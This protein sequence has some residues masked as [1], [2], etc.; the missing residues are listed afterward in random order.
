VKLPSIARPIIALAWPVPVEGSRLATLRVWHLRR[1]DQDAQDAWSVTR[2]LGDGM[3]PERVE[4]AEARRVIATHLVQLDDTLIEAPVDEVVEWLRHEVGS[5]ELRSLLSRYVD[6][7]LHL[8]D[9][10][11]DSSPSA[12][13]A[14]STSEPG[15]ARTSAATDNGSGRIAPAT[16]V[17]TQAER[18]G[19]RSPS[20]NG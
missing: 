6:A 9:Q 4:I 2:A 12:S 8:T 18:A 1:M 3:A 20:P 17:T 10:D 16:G 7:L 19:A 14:A 15:A 13:A 5:V 11:R